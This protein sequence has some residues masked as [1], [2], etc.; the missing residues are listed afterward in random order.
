MRKLNKILNFSSSCILAL[1]SMSRNVFLSTKGDGEVDKTINRFITWY[2]MKRNS[3]Q[4]YVD[5]MKG[6]AAPV[7]ITGSVVITTLNNIN[8]K[9]VTKVF[10]VTAE[11][12]MQ[13]TEEF[14]IYKNRD[15]RGTNLPWYTNSKCLCNNNV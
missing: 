13:P 6:S 3:N 10:T 12:K 1:S 9:I 5:S 7:T 8:S 14:T 15:D 11:Q 2:S 4:W